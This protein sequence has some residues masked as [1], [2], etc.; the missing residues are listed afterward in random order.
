MALARL[1]IDVPHRFLPVD[2]NPLE[3][4]SIRITRIQAFICNRAINN[5]NNEFITSTTKFNHSSVEWCPLYSN[6]FYFLLICFCFCRW[7][8]VFYFINFVSL[9]SSLICVYITLAANT[10]T[11]DDQ[12]LNDRWH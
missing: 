6:G 3:S 7:L 1:A 2:R 12:I 11:L 10:L 9:S 4:L 5:F 8:F